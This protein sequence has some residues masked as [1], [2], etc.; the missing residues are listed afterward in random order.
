LNLCDERGTEASS[1]PLVV[2][3]GIVELALSEFMEGNDHSR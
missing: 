3:G 1:F 2:L